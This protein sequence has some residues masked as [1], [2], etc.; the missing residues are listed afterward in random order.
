MGGED[1]STIAERSRAVEA[2]G[3][4]TAGLGLDH[5]VHEGCHGLFYHRVSGDKPASL[6]KLWLH[7]KLCWVGHLL[8]SEG[9]SVA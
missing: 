7:A 2:L 6:L 3:Y 1:V 8:R 5:W 9:V 4:R